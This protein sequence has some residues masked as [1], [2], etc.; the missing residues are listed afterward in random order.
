MTL[1]YNLL[2]TL[3]QTESRIRDLEITKKSSNA[4]PRKYEE[5]ECG[6]SRIRRS[7]RMWDLEST[8]KSSNVGPR[9]YEEVVECGTSR[10]RRSRRMWDLENTK[11]KL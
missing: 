7:C 1:R 6:T 4:G 10:A 5:V 8:K 9:K 11:E 2:L 3:V